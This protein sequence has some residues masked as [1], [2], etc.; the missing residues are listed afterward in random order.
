MY[1][2]SHLNSLHLY[3]GYI[4]D[5]NAFTTLKQIGTTSHL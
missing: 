3:T 2:E 4:Y 5:M 1:L